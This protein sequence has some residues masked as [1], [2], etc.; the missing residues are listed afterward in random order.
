MKIEINENSKFS[1]PVGN[2]TYKLK[3][4]YFESMRSPSFKDAI[5]DFDNTPIA[6]VEHRHLIK[7][8]NQSRLEEIVVKRFKVAF[9]SGGK[10]Q[11]SNEYYETTDE[12]YMN[13]GI[14]SKSYLLKED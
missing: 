10:W 9:L 13:T 5:T 14:T 6:Y 8:S 11:I 4:L 12:F 3:G 2:N 7:T 1:F